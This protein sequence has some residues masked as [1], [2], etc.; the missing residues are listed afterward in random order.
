VS[1]VDQ[2]PDEG[3]EGATS[4][5]ARV[6]MAPSAP[7]K[8]SAPAEAIPADADMDVL[9]RPHRPLPPSIPHLTLHLILQCRTH[10]DETDP[11]YE[12]R[13]TRW[14]KEEGSSNPRHNHRSGTGTAAGAGA[15]VTGHRHKSAKQ[16]S[17]Q[18]AKKTATGAPASAPPVRRTESAL[19]AVADR[20]ARFGA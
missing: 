14:A 5:H 15:A 10:A 1:W 8:A 3:D 17:V 20:S 2:D 11:A 4:L 7:A 6:R 13:L 12:K 16:P 18:R 9:V 19:S